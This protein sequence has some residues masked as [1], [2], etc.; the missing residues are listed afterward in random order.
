MRIAESVGVPGESLK[1]RGL[2]PSVYEEKGKEQSSTLRSFCPNC[3]TT[4]FLESDTNP[5]IV[6]INASTLD[7]KSRIES[8]EVLF[9]AFPQV[10][11][12]RP[13]TTYHRSPTNLQWEHER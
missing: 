6:Q 13:M 4:L 12:A 8:N 9:G 7:D 3:G 5:E 2:V 1:V 10:N 11:R